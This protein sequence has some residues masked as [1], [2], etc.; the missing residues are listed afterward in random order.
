MSSL[1][2]RRIAHLYTVDDTDTVLT[3]AWILCSEGKIEALGREP[4]PIDPA[5]V[6]TT[7]DLT[8]AVVL[9][10]L[11]NLHHHFFQ[12]VTRAVPATLGAFGRDWIA[13]L[14]PLWHRLTTED[15][16]TATTV[17]A[18]ELALTGVT[19]SVD[20]AF[21]TRPPHEAFVA[22]EIEAVGAVGLRLHLVHGGIT[23]L[24]QG[25]P[26][27]LRPLLGSAMDTLID[28]P[29]AIMARLQTL[30]ERHHQSGPGSRVA[31][32]VGPLG[33]AYDSGDLMQRMAA[34]AAEIG[35]HLHTHMHPRAS[36]RAEAEV[37]WGVQPLAFLDRAGWLRPGTALTH[38]T[39]LRPDEVRLLA[40][41]GVALV[42][43]PRTVIRLGYP[44][45]P[46]G[47]WAAMGLRVGIGVDGVASND[48][49]GLLPDLRLA[50]LLH[51]VAQA[52]AATAANW[53]TA[54]ALLHAVTRGA[55]AILGRSDIG[56]IVPGKQ[57]DLAAFDLAGIAY[58]G[59][60]AAPLD[61]LLFAGIDG[62]AAL[63]V[64]AGRIIAERGSLPGIDLVAA[65]AAAD[66]VAAR[67]AAAAAA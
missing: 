27:R 48:G 8:D 62:H 41:R 55:A 47:E 13:A 18:G 61:R 6:A 3:D 35:A 40:E 63:T 59:S 66:R 50:L 56:C 34:F 10:G 38:G 20:H 58:A 60:T 15:M 14:Y 32:A 51:R 46:V 65:S 45:P 11:I 19:T 54:G 52:D 22:A 4:C 39:G 1:L 21:L 31:L 25:V 42:H 26:E 43:C 33:L 16:A 17:A 12:S 67:L 36:E 29:D 64:C 24:G 49:G 44:V 9:P 2:L 23:S 30:A 53:L 57:A 5:A 7:R 37:H 28:T